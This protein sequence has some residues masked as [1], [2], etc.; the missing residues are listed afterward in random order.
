MQAEGVV[1][2]TY[3]SLY[4][5]LLEAVGASRHTDRLIK[6]FGPFP[7]DLPETAID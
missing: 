2:L 3:K 5:E 1:F 7:D 4:F 6:T